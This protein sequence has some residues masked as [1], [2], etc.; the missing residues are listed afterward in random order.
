M[1]VTWCVQCVSTMMCAGGVQVRGLPA[2]C[3]VRV[4]HVVGIV[5][6]TDMTG[7]IDT[8][9]IVGPCIDL[10]MDIMVMCIDV[11]IVRVCVVGFYLDIIDTA[12]SIGIV[13]IVDTT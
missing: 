4:Q 6:V 11:C 12:D 3:E 9:D 7:L 8:A 10:C 1:L 2:V 5:D 13:G